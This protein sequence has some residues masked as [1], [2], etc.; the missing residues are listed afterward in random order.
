[1]ARRMMMPVLLNLSFLL[2]Y[3]KPRAKRGVKSIKILSKT[4]LKPFKENG[5]K[6][7]SK[8]LNDIK[9]IFLLF[10]VAIR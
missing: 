6:R 5:K 8:E 3:A 9:Y 1:M 10:V 4:M 2:S 7:T